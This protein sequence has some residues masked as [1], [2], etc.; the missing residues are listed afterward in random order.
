MEKN[1]LDKKQH[2][3]NR[4]RRQQNPTTQRRRHPTIRQRKEINLN[5]AKRNLKMNESEFINQIHI[6]TSDLHWTKKDLLDKLLIDF[7]KDKECCS[8]SERK[9]KCE[10][11]YT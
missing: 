11:K 6:I 1:H 4:R 2:L 3:Q 9:I 8:L 10:R 7:F 5:I